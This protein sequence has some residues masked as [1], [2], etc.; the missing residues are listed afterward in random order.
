V[1]SHHES[2]REHSFPFPIRCSMS[3]H[4]C[5]Q[6]ELKGGH[7]LPSHLHYMVRHFFFYIIRKTIANME[8]KSSYGCISVNQ[9]QLYTSL[10]QSIYRSPV[11]GGSMLI[12]RSDKM[13]N[14]G[15]RYIISALRRHHLWQLNE[16]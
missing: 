6:V 10:Q 15:L 11:W 16:M 7:F 14:C 8:E 13:L 3:S 12:Q 4:L 2:N 1:S 9:T 5:S